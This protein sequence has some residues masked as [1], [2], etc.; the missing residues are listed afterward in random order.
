MHA[1]PLTPCFDPIVE[2]GDLIAA[3]RAGEVVRRCESLIAAGRGGI[4]TRVALGRALVALGRYEDAVAGLREASLL[5]P[6]TMEVV[7]A[8]GEALAAAGALPTA[9]SEFQ[10]AARLA[11][12]DGRPP[13]Q[14]ARLWL[15]AGEP[16]KAEE[17]AAQAERL[18]GAG[19]AALAELRSAAQTM[20][21]AKRAAPGYVRH[22]F[23]QFAADYDQRMRGR[24]GYE[25]PTI[26]R[27]LAG[28]L[29]APNAQVDVLDLGC[30]TGLSGVAFSPIARRLVG[31]DL[32]PRMIERARILGIYDVLAVGDVEALPAGTSGPFDV[33]VAADVLV[34]LGDL[35]TL[36]AAVRS[37]LKD[38]GLW[39]FT[40]ERGDELDFELGPKRRY[41]HSEAY[42]RSLARV[43]R[44]EIASLIECVTRYEAGEP[45]QS[46]GAALRAGE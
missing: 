11:P 5:S 34:Y 41:R 43:H 8:L 40:T 6:N 26:L 15:D 2:A 3:G 44:F 33:A 45:V 9:I 14:I 16:D 36:F 32:S 19:K 37:R 1:D 27:D 13:W 20:R 46:W 39:V 28:L 25:A 12:D 7:L 4:L 31:I 42:L 35:E 23:D 24:L 18:G 10:R 30:G 21:E 22:L 29:L 38:G 17:A